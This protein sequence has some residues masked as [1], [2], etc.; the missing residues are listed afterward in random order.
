MTDVVTT[1]AQTFDVRTTFR[2]VV[3][4]LLVILVLGG[5]AGQLLVQSIFAASR[6]GHGVV[7][8]RGTAW[9]TLLAAL[10]AAS[11]AMAITGY[12][13]A[14][15]SAPTEWSR[16]AADSSA[17]APSILEPVACAWTALTLTLVAAY[18]ARRSKAM[19]AFLWIGLLLFCVP[20][21]IYAIGWLALGQSAG[22]VAIPP[23]VAHVS[24]A[25]ALCTFGFAVGYSRL[26]PSLD[27][28]AAL[29]PLSPLRKPFLFVLP[30][31]VPSLAASAALAAALIYADRDVASLLLPPGASRLTLN[32]YLASANAPSTAVAMLA[33]IVLVGAAVTVA[34]AA[35]GPA[36]VLGRRRD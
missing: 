29:V 27:D 23:A 30:L 2:F 1:F 22:G 8:T 34:L 28:A 7:P 33:L 20:A 19:H 17:M 16:L 6:G 12:A 5:L 36:V 24:R 10:P 3:P 31:I 13:W 26:P 4:L 21:A 32:L 25:V 15:L 18:P 35:A 11:L 9:L 14:L